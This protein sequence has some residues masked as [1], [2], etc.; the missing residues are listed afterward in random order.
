MSVVAPLWCWYSP[1]SCWQRLVLCVAIVKRQRLSP[2]RTSASLRP[3]LIPQPFLLQNPLPRNLPLQRRSAV[4]ALPNLL[5]PQNRL[6]RPV[7]LTPSLKSEN[8]VPRAKTPQCFAR[9]AKIFYFCRSS[10]NMK[11]RDWRSKRFHHWR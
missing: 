2:L 3:R 8:L 1:H 6:P 10:K 7:A 4:T 5:N 11:L 9:L